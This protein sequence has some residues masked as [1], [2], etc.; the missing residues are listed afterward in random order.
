[1]VEAFSFSPILRVVIC[2]N[3][4]V[5]AAPSG[6]R[7]AGLKLPNP[8]LIM[9]IT[10]ASPANTA[11]QLRNSTFSPINITDNAVISRGAIKKIDTDSASEIVTR[12]VKKQRLAITIPKPLNRCSPNRFV[13]MNLKPPSPGPKIIN[14]KMIPTI[15]RVKTIWCRA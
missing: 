2:T 9:I 12:E 7:L 10:P 8:G 6:S 11:A 1:M 4:Y 3:A 15:E 14:V 5:L 13:K